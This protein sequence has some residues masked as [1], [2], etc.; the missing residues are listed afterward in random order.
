MLSFPSVPPEHFKSRRSFASSQTSTHR[1]EQRVGIDRLRQNTQILCLDEI[2]G[3]GGHDDDRNVACSAV[4]SDLL[5]HE[6]AVKAR[7]PEIEHDNIGRLFVDQAQR[8]E[9]IP[10]LIDVEARDRERGPIHLSKLGIVLDHEDSLASGHQPTS[11]FPSS[12]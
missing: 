2:A 9:T 12:S 3:I 11:G 10:D 6:H 4:R 5:L 8:V 7:P 1:R